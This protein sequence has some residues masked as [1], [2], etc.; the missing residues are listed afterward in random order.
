MVDMSRRVE[1]RRAIARAS[2]RRDW[3]LAKEHGLD[4]MTD[5]EIDAEIDAVRAERLAARTAARTS[6]R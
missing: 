4:K 1:L 2:L 6:T 3:Q 5:E